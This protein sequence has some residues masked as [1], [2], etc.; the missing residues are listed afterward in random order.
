[1]E[2]AVRRDDALQLFFIFEEKTCK[3]FAYMI[4]NTY[5]CNVNN[6]Q[7]IFALNIQDYEI[8]QH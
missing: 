4:K 1:M 5:L 7:T 2:I 3:L 6:K 8:K